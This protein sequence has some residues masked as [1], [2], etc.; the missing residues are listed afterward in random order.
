MSGHSHYATIHRQKELKDAKKGNVFSKLARAISIAVKAG[1][2]PDPD[3]NFKLRM[4]IDKA[5]AQN[6]PKVNVERAIASGVGGEKLEE[7]VY[8]G[9]GPLG[10][11]VMVEAA[12]DNRNRTGQEIKNLFERGGGNMGGPGAVAYNFEQKALIEIKKSKNSEQQI[13]SIIDLGVD[14]VEETNESIEVYVNPNDYSS[15]LAMIHEKGFEVLLSEITKKPKNF[16][17]ISN[18]DDAK[19][20]LSFLDNI[21]SHDDVLRVHSNV[22][23][24]DL[25]LRQLNP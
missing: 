11:A 4:V 19:R 15:K 1:G 8:E 25:I 6:M 21:S 16:R 3:S 10:I 17:E 20:I 18:I 24:P 7:V 23:I 12:T 14:E 22:D 2:G 13:L 5:K 9:F